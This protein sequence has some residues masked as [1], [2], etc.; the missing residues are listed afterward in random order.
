[1]ANLLNMMD[2]IK[3]F[4]LISNRTGALHEKGVLK[5]LG[6]KLRRSIFFHKTAKETPAQVLSRR[7]VT[8]LILLKTC[9]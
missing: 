8:V 4:R 7:I 1:M 5:N 9:K 2:T 3:Y 6:Q